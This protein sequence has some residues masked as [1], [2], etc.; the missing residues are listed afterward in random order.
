MSTVH[1]RN[2][3]DI[4]TVALTTSRASIVGLIIIFLGI[5]LLNISIPLETQAAIYLVGMVALNLPHGGYE[6]FMNLR[7]RAMKFRGKYILGYLLMAGGFIGLFLLA[8][9]VGLALSIGIAVAKGGG[10]DIY[11]LK[12]TTGAEHIKSTIQMYL[13]VGARGGAVMAV[14][15]VAFPESFHR[16]SELMVSM[17]HPE[18]IGAI[19]S[20]F[21]ITGPLIGIGYGLVFIGH[22]WLGFRNREGTGSW[23]IDV[24]ETI[25]LVVY[26]AIVPVVIAVGLY[27]PLW[28]SARQIARELSVDKSPT[29]QTDILGCPETD[30][31]SVA[32]RINRW[33]T[34]HGICRCCILVCHSESASEWV[35]AT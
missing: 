16:F 12:S 32:L 26:F 24:A 22:V 1:A 17:I 6:H 20:Y 4:T 23:E 13:A 27:F 30:P 25:L 5:R 35:S 33:G 8:P 31:T 19:G 34:R 28:Y 18:G 2:L 14:P 11:V 21:S 10:G 7:R 15:I 3:F 9:I 29:T